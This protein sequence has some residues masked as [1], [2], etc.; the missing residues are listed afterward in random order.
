VSRANR[1]EAPSLDFHL[2]LSPA[3]RDRVDEA[4]ATNH[5]TASEFGRDALVQA[6]DDCL[7]AI[8]SRKP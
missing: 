5:Q 4:A 6:A 8:R 7:E 1:A 3:E 2:R